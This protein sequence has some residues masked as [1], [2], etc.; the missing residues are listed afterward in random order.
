MK[1]LLLDPVTHDLVIQGGELIFT[2]NNLEDLRQRM[3][4]TF[5]AWRG[6]WKLNTNFGIP[7]RQNIF[8]AG[9]TKDIVDTIF[10]SAVL[11]FDDITEIVEF[12]SEFDKAKRDYS[13]TRLIVRTTE[14]AT[15]SITLSN[16]DRYTYT[17]VPAVDYAICQ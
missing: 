6:E 17:A 16:P 5:N 2:Q 3:Y 11:D 7:Y 9:A 15:E 8:V 4:I 12:T 14:G 13:I 1:D 10:L